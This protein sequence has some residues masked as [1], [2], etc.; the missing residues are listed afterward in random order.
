MGATWHVC[1]AVLPQPERKSVIERQSVKKDGGSAGHLVMTEANVTVDTPFGP[2]KCPAGSQFY[3]GPPDKVWQTMPPK[4]NGVD[5]ESFGEA[6]IS[7]EMDFDYAVT[8]ESEVS[9]R[10]KI[11]RAEN[12]RWWGRS[13]VIGATGGT[14]MELLRLIFRLF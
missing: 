4:V 1:L 3:F 2:R 11:I 5:P 10:Q 8:M 12:R 6:W 14:A 7:G 9:L 13:V